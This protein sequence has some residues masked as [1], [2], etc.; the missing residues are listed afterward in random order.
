MGAI[1]LSLAQLLAGRPP[2]SRPAVPEPASAG[3]C[4]SGACYGVV[5]MFVLKDP[6]GWDTPWPYLL[7][8]G[9]AL[10]IVFCQPEPERRRR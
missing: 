10:A 1:H 3:P 9:A 2:L 8:T 4:S 6:M 7:L 5:Q